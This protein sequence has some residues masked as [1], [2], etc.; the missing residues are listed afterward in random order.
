MFPNTLLE[1]ICRTGNFPRL[2]DD[3]VRQAKRD[4]RI[5]DA[6]LYMA[7]GDQVANAYRSRGDLVVSR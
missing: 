2:V 4:G 7:V 6:N 1:A 3:A 5:D